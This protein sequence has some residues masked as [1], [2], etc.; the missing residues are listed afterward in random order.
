MTHS[1][2][3]FN[4]KISSGYYRMR[5]RCPEIA[6]RAKPGQFVMVKTTKLLDPL[7][8]RPFGI[9][10]LCHERN[11]HAEDDA[12]SCIEILYKIVGKGTTILSEKKG[13]ETMDLMGP[14]GNG[15]SLEPHVETAVMVAGGIG[16]APLFSLAQALKG[17]KGNQGVGVELMVFIGGEKRDD[18]LCLND[19]KK[20]GAKVA[21]CTMD[22]SLG[23]KGVVTDRLLDFLRHHPPLKMQNLRLFGCGPLPM[24]KTL[25]EIASSNGIPCQVSLESRM[26]C[27]VGA[28]QGCAVPTETDKEGERTFRYQ[29]ACKEGPVFDSAVICWDYKSMLLNETYGF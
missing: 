9:H 24:L 10:R 16:V 14:L 12:P 25:S 8:R 3:I 19:F 7:L 11:T 6:S 17:I 28:C 29:R 22:G 5:I 20:M 1:R 15:F 18:I 23:T 4:R 13:H 26:A 2:I 21:V 27:G